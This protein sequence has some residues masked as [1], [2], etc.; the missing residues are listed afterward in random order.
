[1]TRDWQTQRDEDHEMWVAECGRLENA[2]AQDVQ[3]VRQEATE[4]VNNLEASMRSALASEEQQI[5]R[6]FSNSHSQ[7]QQK[8][9][10]ELSHYEMAQNAHS[11]N[12]EITRLRSELSSQAATLQQF[13]EHAKAA[14]RKYEE[15]QAM[16]RDRCDK[17][18]SKVT[19]G[20]EKGVKMEVPNADQSAPQAV[21]PSDASGAGQPAQSPQAEKT[22]G[23]PKLDKPGAL[24]PGGGG[25]PPQ[26]TV[27]SVPPPSPIY[28]P[29][30]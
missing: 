5:H 10:S 12:S 15:S 23:Q 8:Y 6:S 16:T 26:H 14:T 19:F 11:E 2:R 7:L 28:E 17:L 9:Q 13:S 25:Q 3:R 21:K 29:K 30:V 18:E 22:G 4:A 27:S 20:S 24:N 1:M